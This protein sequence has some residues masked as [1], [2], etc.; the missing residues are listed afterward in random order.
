MRKTLV[1]L[2]AFLFCANAY[3]YDVH[4]YQHMEDPIFV[5]VTDPVNLPILEDTIIMAD[6]SIIIAVAENRSGTAND[7]I[8]IYRSIDGGQSWTYQSKVGGGQFP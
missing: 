5:N 8:Y 7:G 1:A 3:A 4:P 6:D 2:I